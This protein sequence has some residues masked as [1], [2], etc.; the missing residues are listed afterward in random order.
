MSVSCFYSFLGFGGG[1]KMFINIF[2][3]S[4]LSDN[5]GFLIGIILISSDNTD[6]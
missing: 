6:E 5:N 4:S 2:F 3:F 1:F